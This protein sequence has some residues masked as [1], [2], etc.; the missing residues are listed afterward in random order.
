[1]FVGVLWNQRGITTDAPGGIRERY[2]KRTLVQT[3]GATDGCA[4][5]AMRRSMCQGVGNGLRTPSIERNCRVNHAKWCNKSSLVVQLT[6]SYLEISVC[7]WSKNRNNN[8][9]QSQSPMHCHPVRVTKSR[10]K[11]A[12]RLVVQEPLKTRATREEFAHAWI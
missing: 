9:H 6:R 10:C 1:M 8:M 12:R 11:S 7:K 3:H 4:A 5:K 2:I